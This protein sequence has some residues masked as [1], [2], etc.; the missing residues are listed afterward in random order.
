LSTLTNGSL[1]A[2]LG[3][4]LEFVALFDDFTM[5]HISKDE[6]AVVNDLAQQALGF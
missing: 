2:Y 6:N 3:K 5:Q 1:N 4:C